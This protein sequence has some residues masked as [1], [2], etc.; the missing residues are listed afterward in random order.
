M[1]PLRNKKLIKQNQFQSQQVIYN[2]IA[3]QV[4]AEAHARLFQN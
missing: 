3:R 4:P 1:S 2:A